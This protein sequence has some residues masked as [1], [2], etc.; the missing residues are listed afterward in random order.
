[1]TGHR[2]ALGT[3]RRYRIAAECDARSGIPAKAW[4]GAVTPAEQSIRPLA[5]LGGAETTESYARKLR[6]LLPGVHRYEQRVDGLV[7]RVEV[8]ALRADGADN[9]IRSIE[10]AKGD[11]FGFMPL[12][13]LALETLVVVALS[14]ASVPMDIGAF[15][16]V[17]LDVRLLYAAVAAVGVFIAFT[18]V[19]I[20]RGTKHVVDSDDMPLR[21]RIAYSVAVL[22]CLVVL[23]FLAVPGLAFLRELYVRRLAQESGAAI[24]FAGVGAAFTKLQLAMIF[25]GAVVSFLA[26]NPAATRR[27]H[28]KLQRFWLGVRLWLL[29][30][31]LHFVEVRLVVRGAVL[32]AVRR[33][34]EARAARVTAYC[35]FLAEH[36][37]MH[38]LQRHPEA[39]EPEIGARPPVSVPG[40]TLEGDP[41]RWA[42]TPRRLSRDWLEAY[43]VTSRGHTGQAS[44]SGHTG[45]G[46]R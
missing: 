17:P 20:G 30:K 22:G 31:H 15:Q 3:L 9:E 10:T 43:Q 6:R 35:G 11:P 4:A 36:Y 37:R 23:E 8:L 18:T 21:K 46:I 38:L 12:V 5:N 32:S 16:I 1:V 2:I 28:L 33:I 44:S 13:G 39:N 7:D 41:E 25:A 45:N 19:A 24:S 26:H 27:R 14:L 29:T 34:F 42:A 40:Q